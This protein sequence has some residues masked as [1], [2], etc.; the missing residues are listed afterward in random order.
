MLTKIKET[1]GGVAEYS[2]GEILNLIGKIDLFVLDDL[3]TEYT[4]GKQG[5]D[6]W[7][8]MKLFE[9]LDS[10]AGKSTIFTTN[11]SSK[12]LR[13][14]LNERNLSRVLDG[15]EIITM[16]GSDYRRRHFK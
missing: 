10:R 7:T 12:E 8:D 13:G 3:G 6:T 14:K 9:V 16:R 2:E 5:T 4:S 11:L 15:T 1:Y